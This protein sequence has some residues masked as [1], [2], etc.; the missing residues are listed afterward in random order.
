MI[1]KTIGVPIEFVTVTSP[2]RIPAL[3][4]DRADMVVSIFSITAPRAL[5]V[6][7][8]IPYASQ[9]SVVLA[10][11]SVNIK[12]AK[13]LVGLK[14]GV[15]RGTGEDGTIVGR[16]N[17]PSNEPRF[18]VPERVDGKVKWRKT[19]D[20]TSLFDERDWEPDPHDPAT[21]SVPMGSMNTRRDVDGVKVGQIRVGDEI[22]DS[23]Q[24][25]RK[26]LA[27]RDSIDGQIEITVAKNDGTP[28]ARPIKLKRTRF[29]P[30]RRDGIPLQNWSQEAVDAKAADA[31]RTRAEAEAYDAKVKELAATHELPERLVDEWRAYDFT[32]GT[33]SYGGVDTREVADLV[34]GGTGTS[35]MRKAYSTLKG[36]EDAGLV[37]P[38]DVNGDWESGG[39]TASGKAT[40]IWTPP[41][42]DEYQGWTMERRFAEYLSGRDLGPTIDEGDDG[43]GWE[44]GAITPPDGPDGGGG[45]G[46]PDTPDAPGDATPEPDGGLESLSDADLATVK[47]AAIEWVNVTPEPDAM[48]QLAD[49]LDEEARRAELAGDTDRAAK[50]RANAAKWRKNAGDADEPDPEPEVDPEVERRAGYETIVADTTTIIDANRTA[51]EREGADPF[52]VNFL[53]DTLDRRAAAYDELDRTD[54][55]AADRAHAGRLRGALAERQ[56]RE[57]A[58][59]ALALAVSVYRNRETVDVDQ[60]NL[61]RS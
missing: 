22:M 45:P 17:F 7:F 61:L 1:A 12:S 53:A 15:T 55:A 51:A 38:Q 58:A 31:D 48:R 26:V 25:Y 14:V 4:T 2:G 33:G 13:D 8:S 59:V 54:D 37:V 16:L 5:Q 28:V 29:A 47:A 10:P 18:N 40:L 60:F 6:A 11:K 23:S 34:Y 35:E 20:A 49:V 39:Q 36:L 41:A 56:A 24:Q 30:I 32:V 19:D 46:A 43:K 52:A 57:E 50:L 3:F 27:V 21:R 42:L 44:P 9:S